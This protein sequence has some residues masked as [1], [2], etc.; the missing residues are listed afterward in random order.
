MPGANTDDL[1]NTLG[2]AAVSVAVAVR[3]GLACAGKATLAAVVATADLA[4]QW[5]AYPIGVVLVAVVALA[6][7]YG[8][9]DKISDADPQTKV[10]TPDS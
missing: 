1:F 2:H 3:H 5:F 10:L 7:N 6:W 8:Q 4:C 9:G